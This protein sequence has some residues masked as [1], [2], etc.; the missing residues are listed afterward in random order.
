[1]FQKGWQPEKYKGVSDEIRQQ[2]MKARDMSFKD[3]LNYFWYYYK[4]HTL[5]GIAAVILIGV[6]IRDMA[7]NKDY[8]FY[9]IMLNSA[10]LDGELLG[11]SFEEYAGLD[12]ENYQCFVDTSSTL[13]YQTQTEYDMATIQRI[14]AM[15]QAKE[16]DALIFDAQVFSNFSFNEMFMDLRDVFSEEELAKYEGSIYYID[17]EEIL[18][19]EEAE[20]NADELS[21]DYEN[22]RTATAEAITAEAETH[23]H[24]ENM[25]DPIPIGIFI[26]GSPFVQKTG[27]YNRLI[28]IYGIAASS[29]RTD[30]AKKYLDFLWDENVPFE[31]MILTY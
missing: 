27:T 24:P 28:P 25:A 2:H 8:S 5:V 30:T 22:L 11:A 12:P 31:N 7:S 1:M 10:G 16:L 21:A 20:L 3:K 29:Q 4:V 26:D 17:Y 18:K 13:S 23:K 15:M 9:G 6:F 19:A 14:M